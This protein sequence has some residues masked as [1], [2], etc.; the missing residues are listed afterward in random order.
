[1]AGLHEVA[2]AGLRVD[3]H[4]DRAR[5]VGGRDAGGHAVA[6]LDRDGERG[7]ER[8]LVLGRHQVEPELVAALRLERQADQPAPLLGHEIDGLGRGELGGESE[9]ALVLAILRVA[10]DDHLSG[11]DV[12]DGVFDRAERLLGHRAFTAYFASMS[13]S[14]LTG[15]PSA[16]APRVV[17]SSVS[18]IS[19]TVK[20]LASTSTTVSETPSTA[21]EPFSTTKR[22]I[23]GGA[24]IRRRREWSR[25]SIVS[26][27]PV[28]STW[29][30]TK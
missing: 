18:G 26:M 11:A 15:S 30:C 19:E 25:C 8:R 4:L 14:R 10:D 20:P 3:R 7:L 13:T 12:L 22:R 29:P 17:R 28:A 1:M 5:A 21:I 9:V 23:S 27:R 6:R 16:A 24:P 2:R